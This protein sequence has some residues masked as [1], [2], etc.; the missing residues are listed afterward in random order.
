MDF[1]DFRQKI[2][3]S[4]GIYPPKIGG[5]AQYAKNLKEEF[6]RMGHEVT[7]KTFNVE[8]Y[9]PSGI[10][11]V[12]FF[13]KIIPAV[14]R[15][16]MI[17]ILDT[18]SVGLPTVLACKIF[19]K[20]SV[21]RTGGDFLWEQYVERTGKKVLLRNFYEEEKGNFSRKDKIIFN[22]TKWTLANV[23]KII[24]STE[25]QRDIF[26][27]AYGV[28]IEK[29]SI[30][31][32]YYGPKENSLNPSR[33]IFVVSS[34]DLRWKNITLLRKVFTRIK[35]D[36]PEVDLFTDNIPFTDFMKKVEG[37]YATIQVSLGDISPNLILDS[38]RHN[39]PFI[40]T[41]EVGVYD[42]IKDAGVFIDPLD[43]S[44][45]EKTVIDLLDENNYKTAVEKVKN[46]SFTH[47]W[48]QIAV[49]FL[50]VFK[51]L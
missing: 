7:V 14:F 30:V 23:S 44:E 5:P 46:L 4:T 42:R 39:K 31:E 1:I 26:I 10:R 49:E 3:I 35:A 9:L 2:L 32:N 22:L 28:K 47:T 21:I 20:K 8:N 16:K 50:D 51:T 45:I 12:Y 38:I 40:C 43:E 37:C 27:K 6:E 36:H 48:K 11:H 13:I 41:R 19:G 29:T 34:R 18:F 15:S 17:F 25:W 24:F 33:K